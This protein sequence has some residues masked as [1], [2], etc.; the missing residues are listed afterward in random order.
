M[1]R[2]RGRHNATIRLSSGR[3]AALEIKLSTLGTL[4]TH[5]SGW[6][7]NEKALF[8]PPHEILAMYEGF[9]AAYENR[10]LSFDETY[11]DACVALS[12]GTLRG[13][14]SARA[15]DLL[16]P[17]EKEL[18]G[19][20]RL[21]GSRFY[22]LQPG[23]VM[24]AHLVAEGFRKIASIAHLIAN[25]SLSSRGLLFWDE[26]EA[27]LNPS[28]IATVVTLVCELARAGTQIFI[29]SHDYLLTQRLS[30]V[31]E[32]QKSPPV[33]FFGFSREGRGPVV[34][35]PGES[36]AEIRDNPILAEFARYYAEQRTEIVGGSAAAARG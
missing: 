22:L 7:G 5:A 21:V 13:P 20:V 12:A 14:R 34:V 26:P 2:R 9:V 15:H 4:R 8:L 23:G 19:A 30:L 31:A 28:L 33:R 32:T 17:V 6:T 35:E 10:E 25:G 11:R 29:A 16:A 36:L 24:E 18:G 1:R 3:N 27:N